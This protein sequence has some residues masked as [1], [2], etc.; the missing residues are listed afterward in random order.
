M[1]QAQKRLKSVTCP[2]VTKVQIP[3][4]DIE[5]WFMSFKIHHLRILIEIMAKKEQGVS[6]ETRYYELHSN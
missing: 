3:D 1:G 5:K 2:L 6:K 4:A